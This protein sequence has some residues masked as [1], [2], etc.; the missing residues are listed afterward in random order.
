MPT[1]TRL[2]RWLL[3]GLPFFG[4]IITYLS[5]YASGGKWDSLFSSFSYHCVLRTWSLQWEHT[6][7][8]NL[9]ALVTTTTE[10]RWDCPAGHQQLRTL[11]QEQHCAETNTRGLSYFYFKSFFVM[12]G[13]YFALV[14]Q[15]ELVLVCFSPLGF[16]QKPS[17]LYWILQ[18]TGLWLQQ[19]IITFSWQ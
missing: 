14:W 4:M 10:Q 13:C 17:I 5:E 3:Y 12:C 6:G 9:F 19:N 15:S 16:S 1:F 7:T 11:A 8:G 18:V 2:I